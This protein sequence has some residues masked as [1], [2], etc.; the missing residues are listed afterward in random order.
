MAKNKFNKAWL[1]QHIND[2]YVKLAQK[3]GYRAR[4]AFKLIE[5]DQQDKLIK[6][7]MTIIDLGSR[8]AP[9]RKCCANAWSGPPGPA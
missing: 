5:I 6:P 2:P 1:D 9:G 7:G 4:A 3:H 8:P